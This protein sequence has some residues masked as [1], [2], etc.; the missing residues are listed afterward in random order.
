METRVLAALVA[1]EGDRRGARCSRATTSTRSTFSSARGCSPGALSPREAG[2][3]YTTLA[4]GTIR[5]LLAFAPRLPSPP[6][7]GACDG[8]APRPARLRPA[9][10]ARDECRLRSRPRPRLRRARERRCPNGAQARS[11][12][13]HVGHTAH[14]AARRPTSPLRRGA[15]VSTTST[16]DCVPPGGKGRW[17]RNSPPSPPTR[18]PRPRPGSISR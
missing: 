10:L 11:T 3:A 14:A 5:A 4:V 7:T 6:T 12:S 1:R 15:A 2:L 8:L 9:R 18:R 13:R 17:R 16:C